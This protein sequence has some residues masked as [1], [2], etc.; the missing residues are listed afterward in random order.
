M[1]LII[2]EAA[3]ATALAK[4][5]ARRKEAL[6]RFQCAQDFIAVAEIAPDWYMAQAKGLTAF[7]ASKEVARH[8][9]V[10]ALRQ[11]FLQPL[12]VA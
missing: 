1:S 9:I 2:E 12:R 10:E 3:K 11:Q 5:Q 7:A 8:K 6:M 4:E